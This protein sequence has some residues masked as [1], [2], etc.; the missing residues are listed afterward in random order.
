MRHDGWRRSDDQEPDADR[1]L[2]QEPRGAGDLGQE[3][4]AGGGKQFYLMGHLSQT[5]S[6]PEINETF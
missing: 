4:G 5:T 1:D 6:I 3:L 2:D